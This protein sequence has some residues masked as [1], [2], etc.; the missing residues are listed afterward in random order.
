MSFGA[1]TAYGE[2][3]TVITGQ[4]P[5]SRQAWKKNATIDI[6]PAQRD[7]AAALTHALNGETPRT[8]I[9]SGPHGFQQ[10][11]TEP[12]PA[13][14]DPSEEFSFDDVLDIVNPLQHIPI[15]S[16]LYRHLT[17]D[18]IKPMAQIIG[19]G[20]YGG[21]VGAVIGTVNAVVQ[22]MTGKDMAGN[23]FSLVMPSH[24]PPVLHEKGQ[25]IVLQP[26][27]EPTQAAAAYQT[28]AQM[29]PPPTPESNPELFDWSYNGIY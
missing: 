17:G 9:A 27:S 7:V 21:P 15:A 8:A 2:S 16:M 28:A 4:K 5:V 29:A 19:G 26:A 3:R 12:E 14:T 13:V 10:A 25:E 18:T 1:S 24:T 11:L 6:A 23:A 22:G 20:I